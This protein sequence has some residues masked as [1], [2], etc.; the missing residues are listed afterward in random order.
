MN[1]MN[2]LSEKLLQQFRYFTNLIHRERYRPDFGGNGRSLNRSQGLLLALLL[3]N[4]G[5]SQTELSRKMQIRTA[6]L[7]ELVDK[8]EQSGYVERRVN[9]KDKRVLNVYLT[10]EGRKVVNEVVQARGALLDTVFS[11]LSED[12]KNQLS[13]LMGKLIDWLEKDAG[14]LDASEEEEM[15]RR[16]RPI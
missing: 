13:A 7:G 2:T 3:D 5:L 15:M 12:E 16:E 4:D 9:E 11:G 8:L 10:E 1:P 14:P 6:S